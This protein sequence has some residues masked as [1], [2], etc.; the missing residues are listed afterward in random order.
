MEGTM[1][2]AARG[3]GTRVSRLR[4]DVRRRDVF[5]DGTTMG[6]RHTVVGWHHAISA[7]GAVANGSRSCETRVVRGVHRSRGAT[8]KATTGAATSDGTFHGMATTAMAASS[9]HQR[10]RGAAG[11]CVSGACV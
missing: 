9:Q 3:S 11:V 6:G 2:G 5:R 4:R 1:A 8:Q 10:S 7:G